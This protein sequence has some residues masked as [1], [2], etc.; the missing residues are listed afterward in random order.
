MITRLDSDNLM[1][2]R[3]SGLYWQLWIGELGVAL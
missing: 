2:A 3:A 1:E